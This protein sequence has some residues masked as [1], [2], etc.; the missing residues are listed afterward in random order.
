MKAADSSPYTQYLAEVLLPS[1]A[2]LAVELKMI[3]TSFSSV[4]SQV[5]ELALVVSR[6]S[7]LLPSSRELIS[8][9]L[10]LMN[11]PQQ[12]SQDPKET[13]TQRSPGQTRPAPIVRDDTSVPTCYIDAAWDVRKHVSS[14]LMA[15]ALAIRLAVMTAAFSNIKSLVILSDSLSLITMLKARES[16]A[17]LFGTLFDIYHF[18][19][20][21][22]FSF[23]PCLQNSD[24]DSVAKL[25][26]SSA[27]VSSSPV[28][29]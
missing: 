21:I 23:I 2:N 5:W 14:A 26:L 13:S 7:A 1:H 3:Y 20:V 12:N 29:V 27:L 19:Y 24:A 11:L 4:L 6:P 17:A 15:E 22:S 18:S 25:A 9:C 10:S 28:G 16:S 8:S